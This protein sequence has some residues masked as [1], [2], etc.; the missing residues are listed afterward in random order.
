[1]SSPSQ[2]GDLIMENPTYHRF[3]KFLKLAQ[4][5][6]PFP[7]MSKRK[8]LQFVMTVIFFETMMLKIVRNKSTGLKKICMIHEL[9]KY[10]ALKELP[11]QWKH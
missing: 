3:G 2:H 11:K 1:M 4:F 7:F 9:P 5:F 10:Q 6:I 8:G